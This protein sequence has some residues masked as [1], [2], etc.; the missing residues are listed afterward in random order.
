MCGIIGS[1]NLNISPEYLISGLQAIEHRGPDSSGE[2]ISHDNQVWL[3][4]RRL[5]II[6]LSEAGTQPMQ[7][8]D[9]TLHLVCNGEI[10]NFPGLRSRLKGL[11]HHFYSNSDNEIILHAY[12]AW[13]DR[14]VDYLEGMFAFALWD[15]SRQHLLAARDRLGIKPFYYA[16]IGEGLI[17]ASEADALLPIFQTPPNPDPYSLA[18]MLTLGYIPS[19]FCIWKDIQKLEAGHSLTWG[20]N[21]GLK[22]NAYWKLPR[23]SDGVA[24]DLT[25]WKNLFE[26]VTRE[27]LLSDVPLGLFLSGGLDSSSIAVCLADL[28]RP[29][30][31][32][33]IGFPVSTYDEA[34]IA[35]EVANYLKLPFQIIPLEVKDVN[36]LLLDTAKAFDEPQ[37]YSALLSMYL[38]SQAAASKYKVVISGDGG[39]EVLGGYNWYQNLDPLPRRFFL[40]HRRLAKHGSSPKD[41]QQ[42]AHDFALTSVLHR[43]AWRVFPRFLPEEAADLLAPMGLKFGDDEMLEPMRLHFDPQE[44]LRRALQRVDLMTFCTD[45]I[46]AKVDRASMAHALE[47]RVPFLDRRIVE[48]GLSLPY[49]ETKEMNSK[50]VLRSYLQK[51][52]PPSVLDHPKQGFSLKVLDNYNWQTAIETIRS[53]PWVQGGY[54]NPK[55][56]E[57]IRPGVPFREA[58]IWTLLML[59]TWGKYRKIQV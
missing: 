59:S 26:E 57:L 12:E 17:F 50:Y 11:G 32:I 33:T 55:W 48:W 31:A 51:R 22:K 29:I 41:R 25:T 1:L 4:H 58:R 21:E 30:E 34:P 43:H 53:G 28:H 23:T 19:P 45:S 35:A 8:E 24:P 37:G 7:N 15:E 56:E 14:C 10:Y 27:H 46:L 38:V 9:G 49:D 39:D 42:V 3:G 2:W 40:Q 54:F 47:V 6:D 36:Q 52:V 5:A 44:P 16:Q 13:G 20:K 18:Y